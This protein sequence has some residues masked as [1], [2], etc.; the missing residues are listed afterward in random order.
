MFRAYRVIVLVPALL[1]MLNLLAIWAAGGPCLP[2]GSG[3]D[4]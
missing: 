1:A 4:C 2:S 3:G